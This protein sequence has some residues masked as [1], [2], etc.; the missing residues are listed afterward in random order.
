MTPSIAEARALLQAGEVSSR[1]LLETLHARIEELDPQLGAYLSRDLPAALREAERADLSQPLGGVPIALKDNLNLQGQPC[2]CASRMLA[3]FQSP[4]DATV[5]QK[6]RTAGAIPF[7][8][9]NL[10]EF[11]MGSSTEN[12]SVRPTLNPWDRT[13]VAGGSSG[14]SAV[15]VA[16]GLAIGCAR[17]GH[18]RLGATAGGL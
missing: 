6:L 2:T 9:T 14:G 12:S 13:R 15:A 18:R 16:A 11:A 7:G 4:Y 3:N 10:D 8:K 5:V 17:H 1:E